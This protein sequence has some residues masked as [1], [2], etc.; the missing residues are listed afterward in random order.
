MLTHDCPFTDKGIHIAGERERER[1]TTNFLPN[2]SPKDNLKEKVEFTFNHVLVPTCEPTVEL[3]V[4]V[5]A[6]SAP[7]TIDII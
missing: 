1:L 6:A 7:L 5:K 3:E 2:T 4:P